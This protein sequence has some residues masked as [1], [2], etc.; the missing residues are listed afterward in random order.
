[1][2]D[3]LAQ[4]PWLFG[5]ADAVLAKIPDI[6]ALQQAV[7]NL[8]QT[9]AFL[10]TN[11]PQLQL[12]VDLSSPTP[13]PYYTGL[14]FRAYAAQS[15]DYLFSGG[16]YDRLLSSFQQT[17]QP[18]V[19]FSFDV[20]ALSLALPDT[21]QAQPILIYF[22]DSQWQQAQALVQQTPNATLCL[23]DNLRQAQSQADSLGAKL[24]D[25]T[26]EVTQ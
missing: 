6:S 7:A 25:L 22:N 4:W 23:Y 9:V 26:Q 24:I 14:V 3:F 19:G 21:D 15:A 2:N 1:L 10:K 16:R 13:Q 11:A 17:L 12:T 18:A 5:D 8:K 20:D